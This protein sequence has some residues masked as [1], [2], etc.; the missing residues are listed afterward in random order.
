MTSK[1]QDQNADKY[2][3]EY[4]EYMMKDGLT[5]KVFSQANRM[6]E[7]QFTD[8]FQFNKI[9]ELGSSGYWHLQ[10]INCPFNE[11]HVTDIKQIE[12]PKKG[13]LPRNVITRILDATDLSQ[14][15]SNE[16]DRV[17][18][19]CL[20]LHLDNLQET[21]TSWRRVTRNNGYISIYVHCEPGF[22]LR[23]TRTLIQ[24]P[25]ARK[26]KNYSHYDLVYA[27]HKLNFLHV[28]HSIKKVFHNDDI[29]QKYYPFRFGSWNFNYWKIYTIKINKKT[30][31]DKDD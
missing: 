18:A 15:K 7:E 12:E 14:E 13:T 22:L 27:E 21:L 25:K 31:K 8:K 19:T 9:L 2:Y 20:V 17:I 11:Y 24:I 1:K 3:S 4:Y 6:I 10:F 28:K 5:G 23:L 30:V 16:Y 29:K 26:L